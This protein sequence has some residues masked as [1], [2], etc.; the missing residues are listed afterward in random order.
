MH[1]M[2]VCFCIE[3]SELDAKVDIESPGQL[4]AFLKREET[5]LEEMVDKILAKGASVCMHLGV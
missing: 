2:R 5:T 3:K 1:S 4:D